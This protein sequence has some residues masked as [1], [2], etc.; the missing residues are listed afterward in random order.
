MNAPTELHVSQ[1]E[2]NRNGNVTSHLSHHNSH[3]G[4]IIYTKYSPNTV[5]LKSTPQ[6]ERGI[7][8]HDDAVAGHR[9][10]L[11]GQRQ[12]KKKRVRKHMMQR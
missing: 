9:A 4:T 3:S 6:M 10:R 1:A 2:A 7:G 5:E 11:C 12:K 8:Y